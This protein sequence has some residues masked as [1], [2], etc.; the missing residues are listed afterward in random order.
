MRLS[1]SVL[2]TCS[3]RTGGIS[4]DVHLGLHGKTKELQRREGS[5]SNWGNMGIPKKRQH[6]T[7]S[8]MVEGSKKE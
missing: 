2:G 7:L 3:S 5:Y 4:G 6:K 1:A 8:G